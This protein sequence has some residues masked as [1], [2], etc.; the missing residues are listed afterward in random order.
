MDYLNRI[1]KN[2]PDFIE[3]VILRVA[4][5]LPAEI[6]LMKTAVEENNFKKVNQLAHDMKTTFAVL[7]LT[8]LT[9]ASTRYFETW[10]PGKKTP[11]LYKMLE[12]IEKAGRTISI[13]IRKNFSKPD[14]GIAGHSAA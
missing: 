14:Q 1:A 5:T 6:D 3:T 12:E 4:D 9:E 10:K 13:E 11:K 7:G 2:N 8:K